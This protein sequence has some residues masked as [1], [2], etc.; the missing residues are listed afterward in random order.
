LLFDYKL[1][2]DTLRGFHLGKGLLSPSGDLLR[3]SS[4][5]STGESEISTLDINKLSSAQRTEQIAGIAE[6]HV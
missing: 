1:Y 2:L 4:S 5:I 6:M 3:L